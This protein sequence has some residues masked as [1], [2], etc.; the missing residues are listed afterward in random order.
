MSP[1]TRIKRNG[2]PAALRRTGIILGAL[3]GLVCPT[4][5]AELTDAASTLFSG[6]V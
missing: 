5:A 4:P 2:L 1:S 3:L 6:A